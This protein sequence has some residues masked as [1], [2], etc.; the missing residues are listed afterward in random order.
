[1]NASP[2]LPWIPVVFALIPLGVA[3][4]AWCGLLP[5]RHWLALLGIPLAGSAALLFSLEIPRVLYGKADA[6]FLTVECASLLGLAA[7]VL[8]L[9]SRLAASEEPGGYYRDVLDFLAISRWHAAARFALAALFALPLAW[10]ALANRWMFD[11]FASLGPGAL[12]LSDVQ[13]G[14]DGFAV[15][16]QHA[17]TAGVPLLFVFHLLCR[18]WLTGRVLPWLLLPL[19]FVGIAAGM[20]IVLTTVH[21]SR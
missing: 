3:L 2:S 12:N 7:F 13:S 15:A 11:L 10:M 6:V 21:F 20:V 4:F 17:L 19:L 14:L 18:R 1:M 8:L 5:Y 16:I 9:R